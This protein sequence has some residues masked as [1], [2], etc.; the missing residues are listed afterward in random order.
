M[1]E[2]E[3]EMLRPFIVI[4]GEMELLVVLQHICLDEYKLNI[5]EDSLIYKTS[6]QSPELPVHHE[7]WNSI[8]F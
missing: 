1:Q 5:N 6:V 4:K 2:D 7:I 8:T 3:E